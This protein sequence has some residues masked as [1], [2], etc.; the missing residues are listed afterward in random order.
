MS[1]PFCEPGWRVVSDMV[2]FNLLGKRSAH[3]FGPTKRELQP[4]G[5]RFSYPFKAPQYSQFYAR[6]AV[7]SS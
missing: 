4:L 6:H 1:N 7:A 5:L 3:L 2:A